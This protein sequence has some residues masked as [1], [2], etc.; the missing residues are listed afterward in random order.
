MNKNLN[1]REIIKRQLVGKPVNQKVI[2]Y[3]KINKNLAYEIT[4]NNGEYLDSRKHHI[5]FVEYNPVDDKTIDRNDLN[6][7]QKDLT[8]IQN[9]IQSLKQI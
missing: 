6:L 7:Y 5:S 1:A 4:Q 2:K 9:Y 8:E 3:G